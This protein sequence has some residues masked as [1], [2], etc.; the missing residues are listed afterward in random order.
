MIDNSI[1]FGDIFKNKE[2]FKKVWLNEIQYNFNLNNDINV[3]KLFNKHFKENKIKITNTV[4][5]KVYELNPFDFLYKVYKR[6]YILIENGTLFINQ[7]KELPPVVTG[8]KKLFEQRAEIKKLGNYYLT[9]GDNPLL[10]NLY[11]LRQKDKKCV[12]PY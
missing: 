5:G 12:L 11:D 10:G 7:N 6:P 3:K 9:E 2:T 8:E 1:N 4:R